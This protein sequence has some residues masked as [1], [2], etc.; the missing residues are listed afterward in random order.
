M[1][2]PRA[3]IS[4]QRTVGVGRELKSSNP[5]AVARQQ[6]AAAIEN[7]KD[8]NRLL[9]VCIDVADAL[10]TKWYGFCYSVG[11]IDV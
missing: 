7:T 2:N 9:K 11:Q 4:L 10:T 3:S 5:V 6:K 1:H 8:R